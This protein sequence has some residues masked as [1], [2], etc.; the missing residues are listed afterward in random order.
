MLVVLLSLLTLSV[1]STINVNVFVQATGEQPFDK[2]PA[3]SGSGQIATAH[4]DGRSIQTIDVFFAEQLTIDGKVVLNGLYI[5]VL[6]AADGGFYSGNYVCVNNLDIERAASGKILKINVVADMLFSNNPD[7]IPVPHRITV[8]WDFVAETAYIIVT[9]HRN[10]Q[11]YRGPAVDVMVDGAENPYVAASVNKIPGNKNELTITVT[12]AS[13]FD[14][15]A[16]K[17]MTIPTFTETF[18]INNNAADTYGVGVYKVYVDTKGNDQIRACYII[19][20]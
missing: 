14:F 8:N 10:G 2:E 12:A 19:A 15:V 9:N 17:M 18:L 1:F 5:G 4:W 20:K 11:D 13:Y 16:K 7:A 6:H 3:L